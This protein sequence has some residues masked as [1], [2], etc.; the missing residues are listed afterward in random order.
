M[1]QILY[2]VF[3]DITKDDDFWRLAV[4]L[5]AWVYFSKFVNFLFVSLVN[6]A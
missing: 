3:G 6:A 5:F 1:L 4:I 2:V